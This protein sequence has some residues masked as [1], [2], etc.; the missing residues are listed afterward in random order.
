MGERLMFRPAQILI[1]LLLGTILCLPAC[2]VKKWPEPVATE[3][4]FS[5]DTLEH[6]VTENCLT[7]EATLKG[8]AGNLTGLIL[9]IESGDEICRTCPFSPEQSIL[10][11]LD[12]PEVLRRG[13]RISV[14][15]CRENLLSGPIRFRISG[16][17]IYPAIAPSKSRVVT[18]EKN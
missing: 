8:N 1:C 3:D 15:Y 7:L 13:N 10:I 16:T 2:G 9:E 5:W 18:V 11:S 6:S 14:T 4:S 17:N 12:S